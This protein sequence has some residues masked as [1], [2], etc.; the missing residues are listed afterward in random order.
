MQLNLEE[1]LASFVKLKKSEG[2]SLVSVRRDKNTLECKDSGLKEGNELR[3]RKVTR[4][5]IHSL[6][7][8]SHYGT[9]LKT[10]GLNHTQ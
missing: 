5:G 4:M 6:T 8:K 3:H 1:L 2:V 9:S 7:E 10:T